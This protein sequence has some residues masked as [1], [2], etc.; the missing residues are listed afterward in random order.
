MNVRSNAINVTKK[1]MTNKPLRT[2]HHGPLT[3]SPILAHSQALPTPDS[4]NDSPSQP[5]PHDTPVLHEYIPNRILTNPFP[6]TQPTHATGVALQANS[7]LQ[8]AIDSG[9]SGNYFPSQYLTNN[10]TLLTNFAPTN[11]PIRIQLP[12]GSNNSSLSTPFQA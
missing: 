10:S 4:Q 7:T 5:K 9:S 8:I 12:N 11:N 2:P 1:V 3:L 6:K